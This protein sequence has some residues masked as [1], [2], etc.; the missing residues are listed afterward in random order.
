MEFK[1]MSKFPTRS[2]QKIAEHTVQL[3]LEDISPG[4]R[5]DGQMGA[6]RIPSG[7][8]WVARSVSWARRPCATARP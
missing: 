8:L 6:V 5:A 1:R 7:P 3:Q 2:I 4:G